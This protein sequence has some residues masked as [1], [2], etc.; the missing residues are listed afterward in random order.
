MGTPGAKPAPA[1]QGTKGGHTDL[2]ESGSLQQPA[3]LAE[4]EALEARD[5]ELASAKVAKQVRLEG[6]RVAMR[7]QAEDKQRTKIIQDAATKAGEAIEKK[8]A[9]EDAALLASDKETDNSMKSI[10]G[11]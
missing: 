6:A 5:G 8:M 4:E 11:D 1:Q 10:I 9:Q 7:L 2:G 3:D